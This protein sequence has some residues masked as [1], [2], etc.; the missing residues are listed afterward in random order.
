MRKKKDRYTMAIV[1][2]CIVALLLSACGGEN[3]DKAAS[4]TVD[5]TAS[6]EQE[7]PASTPEP[8]I[9]DMHDELEAELE[10]KIRALYEQR[11]LLQEAVRNI[12]AEEIE[13]TSFVTVDPKE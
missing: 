12:V 13:K 9:R 3:N 11:L 10:E 2:V 4:G 5:G 1:A 6:G 7:E 8:V